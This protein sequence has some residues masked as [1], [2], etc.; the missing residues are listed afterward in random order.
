MS[1]RYF[2][3]NHDNNATAINTFFNN[4]GYT[5]MAGVP[6][7]GKASCYVVNSNGTEHKIAIENA[8]RLLCFVHDTG[9][10]SRWVK[11]ATDNPGRIIIVFISRK[12]V[13]VKNICLPDGTDF[14]FAWEEPVNDLAR[15]NGDFSRYVDIRTSDII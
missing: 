13:N 12:G 3:F 11:L 7:L 15:M 4:R 8:G 6:D 1:R 5:R 14:V 9:N 10:E 2:Y